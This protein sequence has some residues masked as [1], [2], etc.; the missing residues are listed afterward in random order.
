MDLQL[1][2]ETLAPDHK[3][4]YDLGDATYTL[5]AVTLSFKRWEGAPIQNTFGGKPL[6]DY[7]GVPIFAELAIQRTAVKGGWL[8][9][10]IETYASKGNTPYYFTGWLD[11]PLTQ[12]LVEPLNDVYHQDLLKKIAVQNNNSYSGCWDVLAWND[13]KT[14]FMESKRYKKDSIKNTQLCWLKS[15]LSIGLTTDNFLVVQWDFS[16]T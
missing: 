7:G 9:R 16:K 8:A 11:T 12:Q 5:P 6:V 3:E 2:P 13:H 10:W 15:A 14:L 4:T 1:Y